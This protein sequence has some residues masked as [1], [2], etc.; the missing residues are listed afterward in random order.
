MRIDGMSFEFYELENPDPVHGW[1]DFCDYSQTGSLVPLSCGAGFQKKQLE[2]WM[3]VHLMMTS[4]ISNE[5]YN[6]SM[7]KP[8]DSAHAFYDHPLNNQ[9]HKVVQNTGY[10]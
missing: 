9:T 6:C 4:R 7:I 10:R 1:A 8:T 3:T 5:T 2:C